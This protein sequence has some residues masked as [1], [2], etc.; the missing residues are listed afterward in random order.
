MKAPNGK[1]VLGN[2]AT[3]SISASVYDRRGLDTTCDRSLVNS[4]NHLTF[5]TSSSVKVR[6]AM[7]MDGAIERL[8]GIL[9]ECRNPKSKESE[10]LCAWKWVLSLQCLVLAGTRGS[11]KMR[12]K[13]VHA[14]IVPVLATIL[15]N[16]FLERKHVINASNSTSGSTSSTAT[17]TTTTDQ[18]PVSNTDTLLQHIQPTQHRNQAP[19]PPPPQQQQEDEAFDFSVH[20]MLLQR[21]QNTIVEMEELLK[22]DANA[23]GLENEDHSAPPKEQ[24]TLDDESKRLLRKVEYVRFLEQLLTVDDPMNL[25][26]MMSSSFKN[27]SNDEFFGKELNS[28]LEISNIL[29]GDDGSSKSGYDFNE[30]FNVPRGFENGLIVPTSDDVIWCLQLLAFISKYT[31]LRHLLA[32]T[33]VITGLSCRSQN[34]PPP[35][36]MDGLEID[37]FMSDQG[38]DDD[39]VEAD[40]VAVNAALDNSSVASCLLNGHDLIQNIDNV[41]LKRLV[42]LQSVSPDGHL[43]VNDLM[44]YLKAENNIEKSIYEV[45]IDLNYSRIKH[46]TFGKFRLLNRKI[47]QEK[48][49]DYQKK[50][51]YDESWDEIEKF[52]GESDVIDKDIQPYLTLNIFPLVERFTV[53]D[54]FSDDICYWAAVVVRNAN[55]KDETMGGRRQCANFSCG[56]WEDHPKQFSKCRRC[57]RAKY[58]SKECQTKAWVFHKHWCVPAPSSNTD[59][60][61]QHT[62]NSSSNFPL[63]VET[64]QN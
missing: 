4:L 42:N 13:L 30:S 59:G 29:R 48:K 17:T 1:S 14:G 6:D 26:P 37:E 62:N 36:E 53:K 22:R 35:L 27:F 58:C 20:S 64:P 52:M 16:H 54:W 56:K 8:V 61:N 31:Y 51:N 7:V 15:D 33:Y 28:K 38:D 60:S 49:R 10:A 39:D 57:K 24:K 23:A 12:A 63:R 40:E 55:R 34:S 2:R 32:N 46:E 5:L 11:E 44:S 21:S 19:P 47:Y 18:A 43:L 41:N 50:W 3:V 45:K 25:E 9:Y